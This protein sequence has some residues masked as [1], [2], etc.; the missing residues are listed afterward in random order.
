MRC[1]LY[2]IIF[3]LSFSPA[4]VDAKAHVNVIKLIGPIGPVSVRHISRAIE[5]AEA[6]TAECLVIMIDTPGGLL[7]STQM[8]IKDMLAANVPVVV[9]VAPSGAGAG[10]AG[11]F[12]TMSA[13]I[14][15]MA[16]GTSI[17]AAHPVGI[18]GGI[19]DS[20]MAD[21]IEN[22][23]VSYIRS[24]AEKHGRNADWAEQAVRK[25]VAITSQEALE[26]N[27]IDLNVSTLDSLMI[28][29]DGLIINV[30]EGQKVLRTRDAEIRMNEMPWHYDILNTI[31]NPNIAYLLMML[32]F[33]G[34]IYEFINP[35][36]I[37]PGV[38]GGIC[39]IVG[40]FALQTLP[41]NYAGLMLILL[42]IGLFA[43]ELSVASGGILAVGGLIATTLGSMMLIDSPYPFLRISMYVI[44][45][46]VL[47]TALFFT[48]AV[49]FALKA[50]KR[51]PTTGQ[52]GLIGETGI[53]HSRIDLLGQAIVHGEYWSVESETPIEVG[54][55]L[56]VIELNGLKLKV[57]RTDRRTATPES[58][59]GTH[60]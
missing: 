12:I 54:E 55:S 20:T 48:F 9:Y 51:A 47:A 5:Q 18:G 2:I 56:Q 60:V 25:S 41:I 6:D 35:G 29:I 19:A 31:S 15:A 22:F 46:S 23:T 58:E 59:E 1:F 52:Q 33:Y 50:Q 36:A 4:S 37:F 34:V 44:I 11:V 16:P 8:I 28:R 26:L 3:A 32:G 49:G 38:V 24:I 53:A 45:P 14:A 17:G 30:L 13:H 27:V 40:L 7:E 57:Q 10:S 39:V 21:K 42:G 43:A